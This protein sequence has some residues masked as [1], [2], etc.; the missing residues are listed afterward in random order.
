MAI[1]ELDKFREKYPDYND[2][3]DQQL[4]V[5]LA[6][7]YPKDYSDLPDKVIQS[8]FRDEPG[9]IDKMFSIPSAAVRSAIQGK[10]YAKGAL[11]YKD[12]P[13]FQDIILDKYYDAVGSTSGEKPELGPLAAPKTYAGMIP[14]AVG[15]AGDVITNPADLLSM[16]TPLTPVRQGKNLSQAI[17]STKYGQAIGRVMNADI[18]E[19]I[20]GTLSK[21]FR[22]HRELMQAPGKIENAISEVK[23]QAQLASREAKQLLNSKIESEV[24]NIVQKADQSALRLR[25]MFK[26]YMKDKSHDFGRGMNQILARHGRPIPR[27]RAIQAL[28]ATA[29]QNNLYAKQNLSTEEKQV[30]NYLESLKSKKIPQDLPETDPL[31]VQYS[32][33]QSVPDTVDPRSVISEVQRML[34]VSNRNHSQKQAI[35]SDLRE[36]MSSVIEEFVPGMKQFRSNYAPYIRFKNKAR[37][38]ID[39]YAKSGEFDT[40]KMINL[41]KKAAQGELDPDDARFLEALGSRLGQRF[42]SPAKLSAIKIATLKEST[43]STLSDIESGKV[44]RIKELTQGLELAKEEKKIPELISNVGKL[45]PGSG[46]ARKAISLIAKRTT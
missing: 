17:A 46:I 40:G 5:S 7:K 36:N 12:V 10:G 32:L 11:D 3:G 34:A 44:A 25:P 15:L 45:I 19:A 39:P 29:E 2:M 13:K 28:E 31:G 6:R 33:R 24:N 37:D 22:R 27:D 20:K 21:P 4:A 18:G 8:T 1:P 14:S 30:L 38:I 42:T 16:L 23:R 43:K 41:Y 35:L 26:Q 9:I